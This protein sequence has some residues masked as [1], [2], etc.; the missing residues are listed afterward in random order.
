MQYLKNKSVTHVIQI[1]PGNTL[2]KFLGKNTQDF[3][4]LL[5]DKLKD[6]DKLQEF[7][8]GIKSI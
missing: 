5:I 1:G 6:V 2:L 8:E 3:Q 4:T 7:I